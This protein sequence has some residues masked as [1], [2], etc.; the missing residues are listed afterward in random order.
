MQRGVR[1]R[2][3]LVIPLHHSIAAQH[4]FALRFTIPRDQLAS[5]GIHDR[6]TLMHGEGYTLPALQICLLVK[7]QI[8]PVLAPH[9]LCDMTIGFGQAVYLHHIEIHLGH[10]L[11]NG[12]RWWRT[13]RKDT[14][15]VIQLRAH[16]FRRIDQQR[17][18]DGGAPEMR[19]LVGANGPE[20]SL[21]TDLAD[22]HNGR[23]HHRHRPG[24]T[25]AIAME[26]RHNIEI[27][28][29]LRQRPARCGSHAHQI[30]AAMMVDDTLGAS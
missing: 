28:G 22:Q 14:H 12:G 11:Q 27:G 15:L 21:G 10:F 17:Q 13:R 9:T 2:L 3:V 4:D 23:R 20:N 18:H 19:D 25:P 1:R 6:G 5:L 30:G 29:M 7:G 8:I 16:L 26:H 24:M